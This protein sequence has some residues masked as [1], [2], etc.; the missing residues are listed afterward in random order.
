MRIAV[1]AETFLPKIDGIVNT[2]CHL[3]EHLS[4]RGHQALV[5]ASRPGPPSA[6]GRSWR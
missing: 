2:L 6:C 3:L 1:V 5:L 4:R